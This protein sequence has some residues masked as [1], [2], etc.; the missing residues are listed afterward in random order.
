MIEFLK[1]VPGG[2][3]VVVAGCLPL[4]NPERLLRE[5]RVDG[6]IGPAAGDRIVEVANRVAGGQIVFALEGSE[7]AV[8]SLRLPRVRSSRVT[9]II[10]VSYGCL[11]SCAY[12]CVVFARGTLRSYSVEQIVERAKTDL[13]HGARELWITSQDT[14][15]YGKDKGTNLAN[16]L[17]GLCDIG[18]EFKIRVGMM[19]PNAALSILDDLLDAFSDDRI[20][21]FLHLPVQSGDD[22]VLKRMRRLYSVLDFRKIVGRFRKSFPEMTLSTDVIC[23]FPGESREAFAK[24]LGLIEEVKPDVVNVSKFFARPRTVAAQMKKDFVANAEIVERSRAAT[25]LAKRVAT[26]RNQR[27]F[28]WTGEVLFDEVGKVAGSWVGRSPTYKPIVV[29]SEKKLLGKSLRVRATEAFPTFLIG[30]IIE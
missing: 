20:F 26:E 19:T 15:C 13:T 29:K 17:S 6:V 25:A 9:S 22:D 11:G 23:G 27:L 10:P 16:L 5:A 2:K 12:C 30:E 8:P 1:R 28:G 3:K 14:A 21:K 7:L 18:G 4:V 24:T